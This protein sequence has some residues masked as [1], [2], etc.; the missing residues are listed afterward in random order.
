MNTT[1]A[2]AALTMGIAGGPHCVAMC[3]AACAGVVRL[4]RA[5]AGGGAPSLA[6][7]GATALLHLGRLASYSAAGAAAAAAVQGVALASEHVALLRPVWT[8]LHVAVLGWALVLLL[9]GRQPAW[10]QRV[11]RGVA[12]RLRPR[13]GSP[14]GLF[15]MGLAWVLLPCGLLYSALMLAALGSGPVEGA[16]L[17]ALF[18]VGS[19][20]SLVLA[21]WLWQQ[22][23]G[24][25]DAMRQAWGTRIAGLLLALVAVNAIW[26]DLFRQIALWCGLG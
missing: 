17:M 19:G 20:A 13:V 5:P 10:A 26:H 9:F 25:G 24:R 6:L 3:G 18:A 7:P 4:V 14:G 16:V 23:R 8:M 1:L 22:L 2:I 12:A 15:A 11:G 21:P